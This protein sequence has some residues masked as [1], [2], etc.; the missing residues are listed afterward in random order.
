MHTIEAGYGKPKS[1]NCVFLSN[2]PIRGLRA[3]REEPLISI[4]LT[5]TDVYWQSVGK[6]SKILPDQDISINS[7]LEKVKKTNK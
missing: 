7:K 4:S 6:I 5:S 1:V 2:L 3:G